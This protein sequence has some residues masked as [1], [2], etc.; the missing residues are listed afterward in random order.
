MPG[1]QNRTTKIAT[2]HGEDMMVDDSSAAAYRFEEIY[3]KVQNL[4][5][6]SP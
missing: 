6:I 1:A 5:E 4:P 2:F 3:G